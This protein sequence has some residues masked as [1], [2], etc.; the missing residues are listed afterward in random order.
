MIRWLL[1]WL[2][3]L[4]GPAFAQDG[5]ATLV[6][7]RIDFDP[8]RLVAT[9]S[10][11]IFAE[12]RVLRASRVTYLR[13]EDRLIVE[14]PLTLVDGP[15]RILVADFASLG[16]ELRDSVLQGA[17][18]VLNQKLQIA[19]ARISRDGD[20]RYTQAYQAVASSCEVCAENPVPL[21]QIRARRIV[22]DEAE[23]QLYFEGARFEVLGVPVVWLPVIRLPGPG[24]ERSNGFLAPRFSSDDRLGTGVTVPY[25]IA[26]GPSRDLT[27]APFVTNTGTRALNLRY[28]QAFDRGT[29][30][31]NGAIARDDTR[32]GDTRGYLF[33]DGTFALP[34][35]YTLEFEIE[36][37]SDDA[38]LLDYGISE[39]DR[40]ESSVRVFKVERDRRTSGEI[41]AIRTLR[42]GERSDTLPSRVVTVTRERRRALFGG[43]ATW[44][45]E[46]HGRE[47]P[48]SRPPPG[49][50]P[51]AARDV[52]RG[53]V[54]AGWRRSWVTGAG[55]VVSAFGEVHADAYRVTQDP[56]FGDDIEGR[57]VP[58]AGLEVRLPLARAGANGVHHVIEP[59]AAVVFAPTSRNEVPNEDS[60][61]PEYDEANIFSTSRF[62]G[63]DV[64][65]LGN[66]IN[67]GLGYTRTAPSG[68]Q[69]SGFAGRTIRDRNSNQFRSGTGLDSKASDW[70]VSVGATYDDRF[71]LLSRSLFDDQLDFAR[72]ETILRW[73][74]RRHELETRYTFLD[75]DAEAGRPRD[76]SEWGLDAAYDLA[77]DWTGRA[78]W[79]YDFVTNDASRA[80]LGLTYRS[81][82]VTVD[83]DVERRFTSS[84]SLEPTTRFGLSVELAGFGADDRPRARRRCGL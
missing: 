1:L 48:V 17:R 65:E 78:N 20:G 21:W 32:P 77:R 74:G 82:C 71:S 16:A 62:P 34:S 69:I 52:A 6:A 2:V 19:A 36:Q 28:R 31:L 64:R 68:W 72:S 76:T 67:I 14:G 54:S 59:V 41:I 47:R 66:H 51:G 22:Q 60:L 79:R 39:E 29:I 5:P 81:D 4:T 49:F 73:S 83:F 7:D 38:F 30:E 80:G 84:V 18:L 42:E 53:S 56:S 57:V 61:T 75:A 15:D 35:D 12:G 11:E 24:L 63:R 45:L 43:I 13:D 8:T 44:Q 9:G 27:V 23:N 3:L 70:L 46:A 25:F 55:A 40:L 26:V 50:G 58:Y 33:A 10:V 37:A